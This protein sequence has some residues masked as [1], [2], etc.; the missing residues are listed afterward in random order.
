MGV[1]EA[2]AVTVDADGG[3]IGEGGLYD[4]FE[5]EARVTATE[6]TTA[7]R[8]ARQN[9]A[10]MRYQRV[11][12]RRQKGRA[13]LGGG[14]EGNDVGNTLR[15]VGVSRSGEIEISFSARLS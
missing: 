13:R 15:V 5:V 8:M 6:M 1:E 10:A 12:L 11:F 2:E 14:R 4:L 7:R 3:A 9:A